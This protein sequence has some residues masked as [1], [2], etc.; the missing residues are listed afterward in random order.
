MCL[1]SYKHGGVGLG[2]R[3]LCWVPEGGEGQ[4]GHKEVG[5]GRSQSEKEWK[6]RSLAMT[7]DDTRRL[8]LVPGRSLPGPRGWGCLCP[9]TFP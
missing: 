2:G 8:C 6:L 7:L 9:D 3:G 1:G 5:R 4:K